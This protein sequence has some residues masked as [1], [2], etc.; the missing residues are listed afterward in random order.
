MARPKRINIKSV[1]QMPIITNK[2]LQRVYEKLGFKKDEN[3]HRHIVFKNGNKKVILRKGQHDITPNLLKAII[4]ELSIASGKPEKEI[5]EFIL[6][7][8]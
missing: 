2:E 7:N 5:M 6:K 3:K 4:K 8:K 1:K